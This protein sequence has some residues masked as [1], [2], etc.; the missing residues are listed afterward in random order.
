MF[1]ENIC[2]ILTLIILAK[3]MRDAFFYEIRQRLSRHEV[4][5]SSIVIGRYGLPL[6]SPRHDGE[7]H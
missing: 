7:Y 2:V 6:G 5:I 3:Q 4:V 1:V